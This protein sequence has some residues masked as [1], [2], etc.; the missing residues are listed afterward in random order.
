[1]KIMTH[2]KRLLENF[3]ALAI[4]QL[5]NYAL[6]F[7]TFPYLARVL[8][9]TEYG[10]YIFSQAFIQYFILIVDF[11]FDL[12]ATREVSIYRDSKEKLSKIVSSILVIKLILLIISL[13]ILI[14]AITFIPQ[15]REYWYIH[16]LTFGMI[17]GNMLFSIFFYQGIE[18]MKFITIFN[19]SVKIIFTVS[20]FFLVKDSEDLFMVPLLNSVGYILVGAISLVTMLKLFRIQLQKPSYEEIKNQFVNSIQFFWSRV[21]VSLYT[22][23]N[24]FIIGI[25]LGPTAA[26]IFGSADKIFRGFVSLYNPLNNV[27]YPYVA[28]SKD[29]KL[30]RKI[31]RFAVASNIIICIIGF[32]ASDFIISLIF[33]IGFNESAYLLKIMFFAALFMMPS[34]LMGYP[35][36]GALGKVNY[37]NKSVIYPSII[38]IL[39]LIASLPILSVEKVAYYIVVTEILVFLYRWFGV[40]KYKFFDGI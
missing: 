5:L 21:A 13:S 24:T 30:Y 6:P 14:L 7:I 23:S 20:I 11:G 37:V 2:K 36:L 40:K 9:P 32:V 31:F 12:S 39:L 22:T 34:V 27:L 33:G 4:M 19:S 35:L 25:V 3:S 29:I 15:L 16:I 8:G 38:H 26:G 10:V 18:R 1:M 28:Y 17:I